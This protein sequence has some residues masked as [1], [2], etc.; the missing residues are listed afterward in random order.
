[1]VVLKLIN[2]PTKLN[3]TAFKLCFNRLNE[4]TN[5]FENKKICFK[6]A[7]LL[8]DYGADINWII[9]K[10]KGHTLLMKFCGVKNG[11]VNKRRSI[12]SRG[13]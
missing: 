6:M 5:L 11:I 10:N 7:E 3:E 9:D 8:L 13:D 12:K 4:E 1:M 2:K